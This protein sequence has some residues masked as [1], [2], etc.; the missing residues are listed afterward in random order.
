[1]KFITKLMYS[2]HRILGT[3]LSFLFVVWFLSGFVMIY[4]GFPRVRQAAKLAHQEVI[5]AGQSADAWLPIDSVLSALPDGLRADGYSLRQEEGRTVLSVRTRDEAYDIAA[6]TLGELPIKEKADGP[7]AWEVIAQTASTWCD[8]PVSRIDTLHSLDQW[9]PFGQMKPE[10]PVYK[11]YF[12]DPEQHQLYIGSATGS[13]LQF[14]TRSQRIWAWL[15]AIPHW[16]YFTR[17]RQDVVLWRKVVIWL[18]GIGCIMVIAGLWVG[19]DVWR[20]TRRSRRGGFSP[21]RKRWYHWHYVTGIVFGIFAL[22]FAFSGMMSLAD[23]PGWI[24][25]PKLKINAQRALSEPRP[26]MSRYVLD[27]RQVLAAY[28][29]A[30]TLEWSHFAGHPYYTVTGDE[31]TAYV[32]ALTDTPTALN[33]SEEEIVAAIGSVYA[34]AE[35]EVDLQAELID[36]YELYYRDRGRH[37]SS[38]Q[39][40][41]WKLRVGDVDH[42]VYYVNPAT[43]A[44]QSVNTTRRWEYWC[45]SALHSLRISWLNSHDVVRK[46]LLWILLLG[47]TAVSLTGFV[48]GIRYIIRL[49]KRI[50][51]RTGA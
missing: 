38:P 7:V 37:A 10:L 39:L 36:R 41:V 33:L 21:Y 43:A 12:A 2:L 15:G 27:Y 16:V 49:C 4:H 8:A 26:E 44:V 46:T 47:G 18:S 19:I 23:I 40:P 20:K 25:T 6:D 14:T 42:T 35:T 45:Y 28:P 31:L 11:F 22:T 51:R 30:K 48:L 29:E 50:K 24:S 34:E 5:G 1:M 17:L 3:L 13:P 32:D 9:I